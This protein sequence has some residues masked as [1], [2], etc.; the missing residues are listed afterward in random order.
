[1]RINT[2]LLTYPTGKANYAILSQSSMI[3]EILQRNL[4]DFVYELTAHQHAIGLYGSNWQTVWSAEQSAR[5][6]LKLQELERSQIVKC[7]P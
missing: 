1:M 7:A 6:A 3:F 5:H 4:T 2:L